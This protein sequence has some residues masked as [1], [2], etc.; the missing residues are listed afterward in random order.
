MIVTQHARYTALFR[1]LQ[2]RSLVGI[3]ARIPLH[4]LEQDWFDNCGL[5]MADLRNSL[6]ELEAGGF[7]SRDISNGIVF[8]ELSDRGMLKMN[9]WCKPQGFTTW[10]LHPSRLAEHL[11]T[12][13]ILSRARERCLR[14]TRHK[15][16]LN[17]IRDRRRHA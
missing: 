16:G 7:I 13:R 4:R 12:A 6:Q 14:R 5:R 1:L 9:D 15:D 10:L 11:R 8:V 17:P 2:K 3:R